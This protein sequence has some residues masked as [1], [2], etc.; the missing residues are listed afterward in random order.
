[1]SQATTTETAGQTTCRLF[2]GGEWVDAGVDQWGEVHNPSTGEVIARVP[3]CE[4]E[5]VDRVVRAAADAFPEWSDT[6]AVERARVMLRYI[7]LLEKHCDELARILSREHGKTHAEAMASVR[8]GIE[9]VEFAA[10]VPSMLMG[11]CIENIARNVDCETQRHPLG[12]CVGI[13]PFNFPAMVPMWMYPIA[14]VCGNCFV[15]KPSEKVPLSAMRQAELLTEAGLPA[16]V[17]SIVHGGRECVD[18]LLAHELVEA[19][20]FVGSTAVARHIYTTGT[21]NGKRVQA[22]GGAK[23]HI[24]IMPDADIEQSVSALMGSAF[25]CAGERCMAGAIA[26]PIGD[27]GDVV[28]ETLV[29]SSRRMTVGRTDVEGSVDMGPLITREHLDHV[30]GCVEKG[31]ADG[32]E[33][34]LDGRTVSVADA[35]NGFF[36]GPTIFDRVTPTM[37]LSSEEVFGPVLSVMRIDTLEEGIEL[38]RRS[39]YGNGAVIYTRSGRAAREFKR[40]VSAGMVGINVGV[41]APM[42][43]FPFTGWCKSFFGDLHIQGREGVHFYTHQ[44]MTMSRWFTPRDGRT[45]SWGI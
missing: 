6:P 1:M 37:A 28:V 33:L 25:G 38:T 22:A 2:A 16:G 14:I 31:V 3:L 4:A 30:R 5:D 26:L 45:D 8:R 9:M 35:P 10:G 43:W 44:K 12:V 21:A 29:D 17:F 39:P 34:A 15:L 36:L 23:N 13:T 19:I 20:S 11:E 41:P 32:A 27:A 7:E 18:A 24:F 42:A 40:R